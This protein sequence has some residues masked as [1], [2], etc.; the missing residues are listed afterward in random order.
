[1]VFLLTSLRAK[2]P[3]SFQS[4]KKKKE[5]EQIRKKKS[6]Q[7]ADSQNRRFAGFYRFCPVSSGLTA[8]PVQ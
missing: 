3:T 5:K 4:L 2:D 6:S 7:T 1:M 8:Y